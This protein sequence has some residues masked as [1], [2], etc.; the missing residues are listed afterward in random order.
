MKDKLESWIVNKRGQRLYCKKFEPLTQRPIARLYFHHGLSEHAS[1]YDKVF[2]RM[3]DSGITVCTY[4]AHGHGKSDPHEK[5]ERSLVW[6]FKH[7]VEDFY[8]VV[9]NFESREAEIL[10]ILKA[11]VINPPKPVPVFLGGHSMGGLVAAHAALSPPPHFQWAGLLLHSPALDVEWN[12]MLRIQA[13]LGSVMSTLIPKARIVPAVRPEDMSQDPSVVQDYLSDPLN[14]I[15]N[16]CARTGNEILTAFRQLGRRS[17]DLCLPI[18]IAHGTNDRC[19]SFAASSR[20]LKDVSSSDKTFNDFPGGYHELLHGPE[21]RDATDS[22]TRWI[23]K[24]SATT[25][26]KL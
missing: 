7:L 18:Y 19:T 14:T 25:M 3:S 1:R 5:L 26:A 10:R 12:A 2:S 20:F 11:L 9:D 24:R 13:Q 8:E 15:G 22:M 21:W 17:K 23:A 4:D 6:Q 16:V